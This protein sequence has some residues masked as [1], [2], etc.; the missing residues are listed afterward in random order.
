MVSGFM[1]AVLAVVILLVL[2]AVVLY[3]SQYFGPK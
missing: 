2:W 1:V 3:G